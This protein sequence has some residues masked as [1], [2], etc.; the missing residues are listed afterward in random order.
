[1]HNRRQTNNQLVNYPQ[2]QSPERGPVTQEGVIVCVLVFVL[3][4]V[5]AH[6][7]RLKMTVM[8][9]TVTHM[10]VFVFV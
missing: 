5:I 8:L 6:V 1:M 4:F 10:T 9:M 3:L 7:L 2:L